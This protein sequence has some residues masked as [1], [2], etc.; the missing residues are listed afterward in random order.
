MAD[1]VTVEVDETPPAPA[2]DA[3]DVVVVDT[4]DGDSNDLEIGTALGAL[5]VEVSTLAGAVAAIGDRV[6]TIEARTEIAQ[7]TAETAIDT[8]ID[9]QIEVGEVVAEAEAV[10]E[11]AAEETVEEII[12]PER[13]HWM[14]NKPVKLR[15]GADA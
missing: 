5:T 11:D 10:A 8:A 13:E 12:E 4:G 2:E 7:E 14:W 3:P 6:A 15:R 9:A 1:E